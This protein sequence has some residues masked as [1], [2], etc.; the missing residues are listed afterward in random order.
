MGRTLVFGCLLLLGVGCLSPRQNDRNEGGGSGDGDGDGD[1]DGGEGTSSTKA[2]TTGTTSSGP[3]TTVTTGGG[4][5]SDLVGG[6]STWSFYA[7][8]GS[9]TFCLNQLPDGT[10]QAFGASVV[11]LNQGYGPAGP[12]EVEVGVSNSS[13]TYP[14]GLLA[15]DSEPLPEG[16]HLSWI[17]PY[18]CQIAVPAGAYSTY[19]WIDPT[20]AVSE[21]DENNNI[22]Y[23]S[24]LV[25]VE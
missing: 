20:G 21:I 25:V 2:V 19:L 16:Y 11:V 18:C 1:G 8:E 6:V 13:G 12:F 23:S 17:G 7:G 15:S 4:S 9:F 22:T 3:T 24:A 5:S 14:C 10:P